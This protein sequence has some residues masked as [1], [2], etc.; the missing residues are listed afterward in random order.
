[1][2]REMAFGRGVGHAGRRHDMARSHGAPYR[3]IGEFLS[4]LKERHVKRVIDAGGCHLHGGTGILGK[5][6]LQ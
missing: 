1:M 6:R 4:Y 2:G 3:T 5:S